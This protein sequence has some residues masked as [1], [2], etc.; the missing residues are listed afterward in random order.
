MTSCSSLLQQQQHCAFMVR[1]WLTN[2]LNNWPP[3]ETCFR[4]IRTIS[5]LPRRKHSLQRRNLVVVIGLFP[6]I[7]RTSLRH[8]L[9]DSYNK[10]GWKFD[11]LW[12]CLLQMKITQNITA[13]RKTYATFDDTAGV[14]INQFICQRAEYKTRKHM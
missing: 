1:D 2:T 13:E 14:S 3:Y 4:Q 9:A 10:T 11:S 6:G 8:S 5:C 12:A 7:S